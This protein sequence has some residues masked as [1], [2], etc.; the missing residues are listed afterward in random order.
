MEFSFSCF[1][2]ISS[3]NCLCSSMFRNVFPPFFL[4]SQSYKTIHFSE[5]YRYKR[6]QFS[7]YNHMM[8]HF[9]RQKK[10]FTLFYSNNNYFEV[11][12]S[13]C[14]FYVG[15]MFHSIKSIRH[16]SYVYAYA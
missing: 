11:L 9:R 12:I 16:P 3:W 4:M 5:Y 1:F 2:F 7:E 8:L 15:R 14:F 6:R 10:M 13:F